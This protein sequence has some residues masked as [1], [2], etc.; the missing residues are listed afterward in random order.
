MCGYTD[1]SGFELPEQAEFEQAFSPIGRCRIGCGRVNSRSRKDRAEAAAVRSMATPLRG[2]GFTL[3]PEPLG[4]RPIR[5]TIPV[6]RDALVCRREGAM[7]YLTTMPEEPQ[8][9]VNTLST[10]ADWNP[11]LNSVMPT[12]L[13][14]EVRNRLR[15]NLRH[16][17]VGL[18]MKAALVVPHGTRNGG[19][20]VLF[21]S[22]FSIMIFEFCVGVFSVCEGLGSALWLKSQNSDGSANQRIA[23]EQWIGSLVAAADPSGQLHLGNKVRV[24]KSVRDKIHQ[25]KLGAREA[26]DWH[27]FDYET[28]FIPAG[29]ALR[30]LFALN[31]ATVPA[32]TN[33]K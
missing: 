27:A 32:N 25:D 4:S 8:G 10:A 23:P 24:A 18:E 19:P 31:A 29:E 1:K 17:L 20:S 3:R 13:H 21:E 26:I 12:S 28:A 15:A 22:Y 33:L 5:V 11:W 6:A 14:A 2:P 16:I 7:Y 30:I 9:Y